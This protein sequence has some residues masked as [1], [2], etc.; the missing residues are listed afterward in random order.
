M[1]PTEETTDHAGRRTGDDDHADHADRK[2]DHG[3]TG[4]VGEGVQRATD[5]HAEGSAGCA[6]L[7]DGVVDTRP[8]AQDVQEPGRGDEGQQTAEGDRAVRSTSL[9]S[10]SPP[11]MSNTAD[12]DQGE[13]HEGTDET[14]TERK[15]VIEHIT[16]E[17]SAAEPD[18]KGG[19]ESEQERTYTPD[20]GA[21]VGEHGSHGV[22]MQR[23]S[24][25]WCR[26]CCVPQSCCCVES[27]CRVLGRFLR[28][29]FCAV[30]QSQAFT[31]FDVTVAPT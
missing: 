8:T 5:R 18:G 12:A 28:D 24:L 15:S 30:E 9:S 14:D 2:E 13:R 23:C 27:C 11:M 1:T 25:A 29:A 6:D 16:D 7:F 19:Q 22:A 21:V 26:S 10:T 31:L 4:P 20:V 17:A 3:C